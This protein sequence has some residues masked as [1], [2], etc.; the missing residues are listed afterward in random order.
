MLRVYHLC[1]AAATAKGLKIMKTLANNFGLVLSTAGLLWIASAQAQTIPIYLPPGVA[2][3]VG[4]MGSYMVQSE[5]ADGS[6][7]NNCPGNA[8]Q[9]FDWSPLHWRKSDWPGPGSGLVS[10]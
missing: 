6:T 8:A 9:M 7:P 3:T 4:D 1:G 10:D 2:P 5:C